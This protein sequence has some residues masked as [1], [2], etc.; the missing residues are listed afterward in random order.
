MDVDQKINVFHSLDSKSTCIAMIKSCTFGI[1]ILTLI[2]LIV[3]LFFQELIIETSIGFI[4]DFSLYA[5]LLFAVFRWHS[6]IA[7][8]CLL[9][10]ST[11]SVYLT[12]MVLAG[13]EI[14][15]SNL[16]ISLASFWLSLRC[17]EATVKLNKPNKKN[18]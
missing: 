11:Y 9:L 18:T 13:V 16:L 6:R 3:G 8:S 17:T 1:A 5:F 7:A 12:F 2:S 4:I 15:G 10:L 14:G